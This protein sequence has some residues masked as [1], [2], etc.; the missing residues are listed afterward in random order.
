MSDDGGGG[1]DSG[2]L[3]RVTYY[4]PPVSRA[5]RHAIEAFLASLPSAMFTPADPTSTVRRRPRSA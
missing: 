2:A 1:G 5:C 3:L 4:D